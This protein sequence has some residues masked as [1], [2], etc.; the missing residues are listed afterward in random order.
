MSVIDFEREKNSN[1]LSNKKHPTSEETEFNLFF[2]SPKIVFSEL[3]H[4]MTHEN[5]LSDN[6]PQS[7]NDRL[8]N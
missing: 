7:N 8:Q 6:C 5:C 3:R 4:Q 1:F 2:L